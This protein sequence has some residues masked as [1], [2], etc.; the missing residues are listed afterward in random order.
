[1][2]LI[3]R[4]IIAVS[5]LSAFV[6]G[7]Q[8]PTNHI[9][10][11]NF[12]GS[13]KSV[14]R[15]NLVGSQDNT[16]TFAGTFT[17]FGLAVDPTG[18]LW[19]GSNGNSVSKVD[20]SGV[21]VGTFVVGSFPQS[22]A[23]DSQGNVFVAN[24]SSNSVTKLNNSGVVQGTTPLGAG[25]SPIGIIVDQLD[26]AW[27]SGF[28]ASTS[29][30][31]QLFHLDN[32]GVVTNTFSY[33]STAAGFGFSFPTVDA[34]G[35]VWVANQARLSVMQI[36]SAGTVLSE[37]PLSPGL[38]RGCEVDGLGFCWVASQGTGGRCFKVDQ[39]GVVVATYTAPSGTSFTTVSIDA[40]GDPWVFGF[41]SGS[42]TKLWQVDATVLATTALP[43]G[44]SA[45]GGDSGSY[46][47]C[48]DLSPSGDFDGDSF[49]NGDEVANGTNPLD[50]RSTPVAPT[51]IQSGVAHPGSTVNITMRLRPDANLPYI[52]A[53][54]G[55]DS[56]GIPLG[57]SRIVPLNFD[58]LFLISLQPNPFFSGFVGALDANGDAKAQA[59]IPADPGLVGLSFAV[60]FV[61]LNPSASLGIQTVS[62]STIINIL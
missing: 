35:D 31:H 25:V 37:T 20:T 51:P 19:V 59:F 33:T 48:R 18:N 30:V 12:S 54:S 53:A 32:A 56:P 36:D 22:V 43:T 13:T 49:A 42:A 34:N 58:A 26:T 7:A 45:W 29:T 24:R 40:N 47:L 62:N 46:H 61:T 57:D 27:V 21:T 2:K 1:M 4:R 39:S 5:I 8:Q 11:T 15:L 55:G 44:G 6:C 10:A 60:A 52:M 38:P 23:T 17:P 41:S 9:W 50:A 14:T 16:F 28:H 3:H